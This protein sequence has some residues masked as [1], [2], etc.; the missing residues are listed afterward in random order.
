MKTIEKILLKIRNKIV[1]DSGNKLIIREK[2]K[3]RNSKIKIRGKN[4]VLELEDGV[5]LNGV[6]IEIRGKNNKI[7]IGKNTVIGKNTY[8]S[9]KE[10]N[11]EVIIGK[12]CMFSRNIVVMTSDG[13]SIYCENKRINEAKSI[14]I[15]DEVWLA[16]NIIVLKGSKIS[17]GTVVGTGSIVTKEFNE[18]N[19]ILVGNPAKK[20]KDNISWNK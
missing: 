7:K 11:V 1:V 4:H 5:N 14:F 15:D 19:I 18:K 13:H 6:S 20:I 9:A 16:D 8:I 10:E 2:T 17:S 12:N 3:I